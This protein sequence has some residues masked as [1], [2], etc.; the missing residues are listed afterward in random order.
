MK[1]IAGTGHRPDKLVARGLNAYSTEQFARLEDLAK[2]VIGHLEP[3]C[4]MSGMA[5]GWDMALA[6]AAAELKVPYIAAIPFRGQQAKWKTQLWKDLY[7]ALL[8]TA[9]TVLVSAPD[10]D[11]E[12]P[13]GDI[14]KALYKRNEDMLDA[15]A[16]Y[17]PDSALVALWNGGPKGGTAHAVKAAQK[18]GLPMRNFWSSWTAHA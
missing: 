14:V 13:Y 8:G 4:V 15:I 12:S 6:S 5:L 18:R 9:T 11:N 2:A 17:Q 3:K 10:V 16:E 1:L 7:D